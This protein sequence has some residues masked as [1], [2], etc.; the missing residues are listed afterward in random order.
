M[1]FGHKFGFATKGERP[2]S[3]IKVKQDP[4]NKLRLLKYQSGNQKSEQYLMMKLRTMG[5]N[6]SELELDD[7][8]MIDII[9]EIK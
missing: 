4:L 2:V 3:V 7:Q 6:M 1:R 5:I 8:I 9:R